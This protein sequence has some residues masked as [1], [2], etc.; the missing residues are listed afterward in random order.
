MKYIIY[1]LVA[2]TLLSCGGDPKGSDSK[3]FTEKQ[4]SDF[5]RFNPQWTTNATTE[6]ETTEKFKHKMINLS[7]EPEFLS[8]F[9]LQLTAILDTT[10]REQAVKLA[11]FKSFK[12]SA[13]PKESLLNDLELEVRGIMSIDQ[14]ANLNVDKKY[15]LKGMLYKQGKRAD[16]DFYNSGETPTYKLGKYTFWNIAAKPL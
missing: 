9:P 10:V 14:V 15:T 6:A 13:R 1:L 12:D 11:V 4:V 5:I 16:V 2:V 7:N 8:D 3:I